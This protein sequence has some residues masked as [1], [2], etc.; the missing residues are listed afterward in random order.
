MTE[1]ITATRPSSPSVPGDCAAIAAIAG[2]AVFSTP[3]MLM[4]K[5]RRTWSFGSVASPDASVVL[6]DSAGRDLVL[7]KLPAMA[8]PVDLKPRT[9]VVTLRLPGGVAA[10]GCTVEIDPHRKL[11][12]ITTRNN[13][14]Q[15]K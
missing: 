3:P 5:M 9:T 14:V 12:E 13:A 4:S 2:R 6:I 11:E 15:L 7:E 8:A 1:A 10:S